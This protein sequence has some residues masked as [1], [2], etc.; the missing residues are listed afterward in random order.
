MTEDR[1]I[2]FKSLTLITSPDQ[3]EIEQWWL[4]SEVWVV[5]YGLFKETYFYIG[6]P[7]AKMSGLYHC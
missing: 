2:L 7:M 3:I 5:G 1:F 6:I 4:H